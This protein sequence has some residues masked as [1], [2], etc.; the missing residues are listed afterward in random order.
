MRALEVDENAAIQVRK[1]LEGEGAGY[2]EISG[3][4]L[5]KAK[6]GLDVQRKKLQKEAE[7][8]KRDA[9]LA[10][11]KSEEE[12]RRLEESKSIVLQED[13]SWPAATAVSHQMCAV[14]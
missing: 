10:A 1:V 4:A 9:E 13:G 5:K 14:Y 11:Q 8:A 3:A 7:K 6:K 12:K 2:A